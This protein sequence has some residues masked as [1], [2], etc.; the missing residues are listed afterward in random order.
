MDSS[1][2][3]LEQKFRYKVKN[4]IDYALSMVDKRITAMNKDMQY[5]KS[6]FYENVIKSNT[7]YN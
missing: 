7:H 2:I 6:E 5:M 3:F 1:L 4:I